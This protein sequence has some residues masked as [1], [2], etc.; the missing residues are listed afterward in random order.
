MVRSQWDKVRQR[1]NVGFIRHD[2]RPVVDVEQCPISMPE[3]NE[4]LK[5]VRAQPPPKGGLKVVV[6]MMP[7][8][9][10]APP[11]SFFPKQF[12]LLPKMVET[13]REYLR[14]SGAR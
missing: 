11:D 7:E 6:R 5:A 12:F 4:Q 9:W 14:Q 2:N 10:E 13:A 3:I 8:G 1:L